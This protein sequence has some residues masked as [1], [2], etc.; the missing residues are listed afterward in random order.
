MCKRIQ[1]VA[2]TCKWKR[3]TSSRSI[4]FGCPLMNCEV[5]AVEH[6]SAYLTG[7]CIVLYGNVVQL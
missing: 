4:E 2:D 1:T 5:S 3:A 7:I 6:S